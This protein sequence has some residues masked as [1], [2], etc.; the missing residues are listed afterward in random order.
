LRYALDLADRMGVPRPPGARRA[1]R[2][3]Q[4]TLGDLHDRDVLL[5]TLGDLQAPDSAFGNEVEILAQFVSAEAMQTHTR[6]MQER[7]RLLEVCDEC[8]AQARPRQTDRR[9]I[10]AAAVPAFLFLWSRRRR[11]HATRTREDLESMP[12][13]RQRTAS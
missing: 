11:S 13:A 3:T 12:A 1:L 10:A 9:V 2:Q 6:Y 4:A 5:T 7:A 8:E